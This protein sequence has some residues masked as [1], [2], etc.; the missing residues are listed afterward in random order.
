MGL[1][2]V[3]LLVLGLVGICLGSE[4]TVFGCKKMACLFRLTGLFVGLTLI[5]V[6]TSLP[7]MAVSIAGGLGRLNGI[8]TSSVVI[9]DQVGSYPNMIALILG[10]IGLIGGLPIAQ[11]GLRREGTMLI[12][13]AAL[14][15][16]VAIDYEITQLEGWVLILAYLLYLCYVAKGEASLPKMN[17]ERPKVRDSVGVLMVIAGFGLIIPA[18]GAVVT[19][20]IQLAQAWHISPLVMGALVVGLGTSLPELTLSVSALR[21][22]CKDM[23]VGN[24]VGSNI[25]DILFAL[26][27]GATISGFK[28]DPILLQ[29]DIPAMFLFAL[30]ALTLLRR[31]TGLRRREG[32]ILVLAYTFYAGL[33]LTFLKN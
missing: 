2:P 3:T 32:L 16:L 11:R 8:E 21:N 5:A 1:Q 26:G 31:R 10:I 6:G 9:G 15:S 18:A 20:G 28:V 19:G 17:E 27:I 33:K 29:F 12:F 4:L 24:L 22:G 7:E 30:L 25:C 23:V 14:F 13:S